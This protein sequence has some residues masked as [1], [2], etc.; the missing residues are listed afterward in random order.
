LLAGAG[1]LRDFLSS[2]LPAVLAVL[3]FRVRPATLMLVHYP[4]GKASD[5]AQILKI[6]DI[7][8]KHN[9]N[10]GQTATPMEFIFKG[11][12]LGRKGKTRT[13]W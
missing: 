3:A 2:V 5:W 9:E 12:Q 10:L 1:G 7:I 11:L 6:S 8:T 13:M 4:S